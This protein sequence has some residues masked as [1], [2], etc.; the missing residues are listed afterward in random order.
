MA[1]FPSLPSIEGVIHVGAHHGEEYPCYVAEGVKRTLW[2]EPQH[3]AYMALQTYLEGRSGVGLIWAAC[4]AYD[5]SGIMYTETVNGGASSSLLEPKDH[6]I[7]HPH[8]TFPGK[9]SVKVH[10][11]D[12]LLA[13]IDPPP[14]YQMLV[15][16]TQGYELEVLKGATET[17]KS[18]RVIQAEI[19]QREVYRG[20]PMVGDLDCFLVPFGFKREDTFWY[21]D[22][23]KAYAGE[24]LWVKS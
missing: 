4:G 16:D 9:E 23:D 22:P 13:A 14:S 2:I 21:G 8:I 3:D 10:R 1:H 24:G 20:C 11:L 19:A 15:L 6:L 5:G 18:I 17:L 12:T 7:E